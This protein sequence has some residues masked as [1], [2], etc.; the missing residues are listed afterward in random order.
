VVARGIVSFLRLGG[1]CCSW[2]CCGFVKFVL[3]A[4]VVVA[5]AVAQVSATSG[6]SE[7]ELFSGG[8]RRLD[9]RHAELSG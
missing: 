3:T 2:S 6:F 1:R 4:M 5:G 7:R 9:P 8:Y